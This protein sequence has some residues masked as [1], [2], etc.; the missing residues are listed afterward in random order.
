[1]GIWETTDFWVTFVSRFFTIGAS[2]IAIWVFITKRKQFSDFFIG[3]ISY[4]N[5][6]AIRQLQQLIDQMEKCS[7]HEKERIRM[8]LAEIRGTIEA[9]EILLSH[10]TEELDEIVLYL[11]R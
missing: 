7:E 9:S 3:L 6:I 5:N 2:G 10:L 4:H 1:M 11:D 8:L